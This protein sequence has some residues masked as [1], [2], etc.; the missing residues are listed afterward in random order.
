[1]I[2]LTLVLMYASIFEPSAAGIGGFLL[3]LHFF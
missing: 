3:R 2:I 1:M